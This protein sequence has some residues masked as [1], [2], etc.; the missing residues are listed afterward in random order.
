M[1]S[2]SEQ[3]DVHISDSESDGNELDWEIG[4]S[5]SSDSDTEY[6]GEEVEYEDDEEFTRNDDILVDDKTFVRCDRESYP[7]VN[8]EWT[9][10]FPL[11]SIPKLPTKN[12]KSDIYG[13][14]HDELKYFLILF[15]PAM[16]IRQ[17]FSK[18]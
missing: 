13:V 14:E 9:Q 4:D 10:P 5:A 16:L 8:G 11:D 12:M 3:M 18:F 6:D 7:A 17:F 15:P 1:A 2:S